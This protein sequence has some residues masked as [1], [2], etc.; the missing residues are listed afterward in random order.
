MAR[1]KLTDIQKEYNKAYKRIQNFINRNTKKGY[2][3]NEKD[4]PK[5]LSRPTK[6]SIEKIKA[7]NTKDLYKKAEFVDYSTGEIIPAVEQ[8]KLNRQRRQRKDKPKEKNI[9]TVSISTTEQRERKTEKYIPEI[10]IIDDIRDLLQDVQN[11]NYK[12]IVLDDANADLVSM[13]DDNYIYASLDGY[14]N[15]Y[16]QHLMDNE[17]TLSMYIHEIEYASG[18]SIEDVENQMQQSYIQI[19][20]ILNWQYTDFETVNDISNSKFLR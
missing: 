10:S 17:A 3:F 19:A 9:P 7:F 5:K 11:R 18:S 15:E 4:I 6:K 2:I 1:K 20:S 12:T 8:L 16:L 13:L 14:E